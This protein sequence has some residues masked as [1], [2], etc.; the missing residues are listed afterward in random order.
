MRTVLANLQSNFRDA[1]HLTGNEILE[2]LEYRFNRTHPTT[3]KLVIE[4]SFLMATFIAS[5]R[6]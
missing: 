2:T 3:L 6:V 4:V 1:I 5:F